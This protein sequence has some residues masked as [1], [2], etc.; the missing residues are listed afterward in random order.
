VLMANLVNK[1][2]QR[3]PEPKTCC[4]PCCCCQLA[5]PLLMLHYRTGTMSSICKFTKMAAGAD[6]CG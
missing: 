1:P 6:K 4:A 2:L 5:L 3:Q